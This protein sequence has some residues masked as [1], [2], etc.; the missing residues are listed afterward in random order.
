MGTGNA[1]NGESSRVTW[2]A[3]IELSVVLILTG[4]VY[5][6]LSAFRLVPGGAGFLDTRGEVIATTAVFA[7]A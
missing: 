2:R 6:L 3:A 1:A 5:L 4:C 7:G